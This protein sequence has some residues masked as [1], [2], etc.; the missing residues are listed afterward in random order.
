MDEAFKVMDHTIL[1]TFGQSVLLTFSDQSSLETLGIINKELVALGMYEAVQGEV[2]VLSVDSAI[3]LK[4]GDTVLANGQV[5][6]V[7]R[8]L[9]DDGYLAK[10]NIY[11]H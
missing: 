11:A 3:R 4:P 2:T 7:D 9:K 6:E 1:S 5:Y 10:W 8:K